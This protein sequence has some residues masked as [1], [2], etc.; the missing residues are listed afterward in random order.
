MPPRGMAASPPAAPVRAAPS[1]GQEECFVVSK[2]LILRLLGAVFFFA[3]SAAYNQNIF[4]MGSKGLAPANLYL[5]HLKA[6]NTRQ[7]GSEAPVRGFLDHPTIFWWLP[8]TDE[9]LDRTA[10]AGVAL[11][12]LVC[13]L[14]DGRCTAV[15]LLALWLLY[16][17]MLTLAGGSAFYAYG[18]EDLLLETSF[19]A[20]FLSELPLAT[21]APGAAWPRPPS[22]VALWL[23][24]WL[25]FRISLGSGLVKLR[26]GTCW[27]ERSCLHYHFETQALPSPL[28]FIFHFL[29]RELLSRAVDLDLSVQLYSVW[30]VL[31][32]GTCAPLRFLRRV[33]G[34]A[35]AGFMVNIMLSGNLAF[36]NHLTI[37][38]ALA[39]LDDSCWPGWLRRWCGCPPANPTAPQ[40][41]P[42]TPT[43]R[44]TASCVLCSNVAP[45]SRL[46]RAAR[47]VIDTALALVVARLSWPVVANLLE[48]EG[49]E[50]V[51]N[52]AFG[53]FRLVNT[54]GAF[55]DVAHERYEAIIAVHHDGANGG[56]HELDLPCKPGNVTR[57]PCFSAPYHYRLDWNIHYL[58]FQPHR[59]YLER[60]EPWVYGLLAK[61]LAAD[62][63]ALALLDPAAMRSFHR[64]SSAP[65]PTAAVGAGAGAGSGAGGLRRP[66]HARVEMWRYEMAAPLWVLME[67]Y[68]AGR[69]VVWWK[70][71]FIE[72]L[73]PPMRLGPSGRLVPGAPARKDKRTTSEKKK[74]KKKKK[75]K[76]KAGKKTATRG[77]KQKKKSGDGQAG[78]VGTARKASTVPLLDADGMSKLM[79]STRAAFVKYDAEGCSGCA[80]LAPFWEDLA[81]ALP[82]RVWRVDCEDEPAV[83]QD[84]GVE[85]GEPV[86]EAWSRHAFE[87]YHGPRS[88]EGL[89]IFFK[90]KH[91]DDARDH[92]EL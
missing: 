12:G 30:L 90:R 87:R 35:Q 40:P 9:T 85:H 91:D 41:Q 28:S 69:Q 1:A 10:L 19:L 16:L 89:L 29:P 20:I 24:R 39:C 34:V 14:G 47:L 83:C 88:T 59:V 49:K 50:Q 3:F 65:A 2:V 46:R 73:I 26:G 75:E 57:R 8:L 84:R 38:P 55:K 22:R 11:S 56:W 21:A 53:T 60:R 67:D 70:R 15:L 6:E 44:A 74:K 42:P 79:Q 32:P 33:G 51:M 77:S 25:I 18:W 43:A 82:G 80:A 48:L 17:S 72:T 92:D 52:S 68:W 66:T 78:R 62:R 27:A 23:L 86:F 36:M 71:R 31:L 5:D 64:S 54:Y 61:L 13:V 4:L 45:V 81:G 7:H 76:H 37:V 58:G 63:A